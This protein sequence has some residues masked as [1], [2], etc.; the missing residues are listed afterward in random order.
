M[1]LN[2]NNTAVCTSWGCTETGPLA[3]WEGRNEGHEL[4]HASCRAAKEANNA[5]IT[6]QLSGLRSARRGSKRYDRAM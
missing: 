1:E 3:I 6:G 4:W 2:Q 5:K